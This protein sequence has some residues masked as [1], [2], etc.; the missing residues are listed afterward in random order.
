MR[1]K[2]FAPIIINIIVLIAIGGVFYFRMKKGS[3]LPTPTQTPSSATTNVP[4]QVITTTKPTVGSTANWKTY[5]ND[6]YGFSFRYDPK[7][8]FQP[9]DISM[10][11]KVDKGGLNRT[12]YFI[13]L[14]NH[15]PPTFCLD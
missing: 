15:Q 10:L 7:L 5:Q 8:N 1:Q 11:N 9:S 2:G 3:A 12:K 13:E 6:K 4:T 14:N